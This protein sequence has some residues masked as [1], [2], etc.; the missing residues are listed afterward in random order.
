MI[1][2]PRGNIINL[3]NINKATKQEFDSIP[4]ISSTV[5]EAIINYRNEIKA[6]LSLEDLKNFL[7]KYDVDFEEI[8]EYFTV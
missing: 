6:F 8:R 5:A 2:I 3:L 1:I 7:L 4:G